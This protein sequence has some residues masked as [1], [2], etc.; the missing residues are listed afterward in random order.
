MGRHILLADDSVTI[1]R[2]VELTFSDE[3]YTVTAVSNGQEALG[4]MVSKL[5]DIILADA[6]MPALDGYALCAKVKSDAATRHI[7]VLLLTGAYEEFDRKRATEAG[8][9]G[10]ITKPFDSGKL[11]NR[12]AKLIADGSKLAPQ[13]PTAAPE[14]ATVQL[15]IG[16]RA[17]AAETFPA[18][19]FDSASDDE[20]EDALDLALGLRAEDEAAAESLWQEPRKDAS[21]TPL[22][23]AH[24]DGPEF[25]FEKDYDV[26][27]QREVDESEIDN[28]L[29]AEMR[30][31]IDF[32][33]LEESE[34]DVAPV[35]P[36]RVPPLDRGPDAGVASQVFEPAELA[37][38]EGVDVAA[39]L[40]PQVVLSALERKFEQF[41]SANLDQILDK[42]ADNLGRAV[43]ARLV[44]QIETRDLPARAQ[45][46]LEQI[47]WEVVPDLAEITIRKEIDRIKE[48]AA[49]H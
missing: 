16:G 48:A 40:D 39:M 20:E 36:K 29:P 44:E 10:Y 1:Q 28:E 27:K 46:A 26:T 8:M 37:S 4:A 22:R 2:V 21:A 38:P 19:S 41:L 47:A 7:P 15:A 12:V 6:N 18:V 25:E 32:M 14:M 30:S 49:R 45:E 31:P 5:P 42:L 43:A 13:E 33:G 23:D 17:A 9:D 3:G 24:D 35:P 11:V 34:E